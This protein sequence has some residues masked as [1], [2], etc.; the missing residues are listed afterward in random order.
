MSHIYQSSKI[1]SAA[2]RPLY[3][4]TSLAVN[5]FKTY[6]N[7]MLPEIAVFNH[8]NPVISIQQNFD[9]LLICKTH[10]SRSPKDS[11]YI[12]DSHMFRTHLTGN[13]CEFLR[14][15]IDSFVLSGLVLRRDE[16]DATHFPLF[17]QIEGVHRVTDFKISRDCGDRYDLVKLSAMQTSTE[18]C[19]YVIGACHHLMDTLEYVLKRALG[20]N[21]SFRWAAC[22]FPFTSPSFELEINT[23]GKWVEM[24]GCGI[25]RREIVSKFAKEDGIYW[26]FGLGAERL[27]MKLFDIPDIRLLW[28][29]DGRVLDQFSKYN[30]GDKLEYKTLSNQPPSYRDISFWTEDTFNDSDFFDTVRTIDDNIVESVKELDRYIDPNSGRTSKTFRIVFRSHSRP[31]LKE[32][33]DKVFI[34]IRDR[35][36]KT[37]D[38]IIR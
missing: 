21:I 12:S 17:H 22:Q 18:D 23:N 36:G 27:A 20:D 25:L 8:L 15:G 7:E 35:C 14:A 13:E 37:Y 16:I 10:P 5:T 1:V 32:E 30:V 29:T 24:L 11:Y 28:T 31:L 33:V 4:P 34:E 26:A 2:T 38:A 3:H 9:D 19:E 6:L